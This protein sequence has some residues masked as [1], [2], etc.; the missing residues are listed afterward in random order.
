MIIPEVCVCVSTYL[1]LSLFPIPHHCLRSRANVANKESAA[2]VCPDCVCFQCDIV[3]Q[4]SREPVPTTV[5]R[6]ETGK[7]GK[8]LFNPSCI[9][10]WVGC[11][12]A[13]LV[14]E[15]AYNGTPDINGTVFFVL[16]SEVSFR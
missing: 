4:A 1:V 6:F 7:G 14:H 2:A 12:K 16:Y 9:E 13:R 15:F 3:K 8:L 10:L 5:G 11:G